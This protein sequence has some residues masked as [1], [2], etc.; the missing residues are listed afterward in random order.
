MLVACLS[1]NVLWLKEFIFKKLNYISKV[2]VKNIV[3]T[4]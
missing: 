3:I 2:N 1:P 4:F